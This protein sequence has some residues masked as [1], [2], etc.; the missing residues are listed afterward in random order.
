VIDPTILAFDPLGSS[1]GTEDLWRAPVQNTRWGWNPA[2]AAQVQAPT[3]VIRG[4]LDTQAPE[5]GVRDL[6][7]DLGTN[8]KVFVHVACAAHQ[9]VWETQHMILLRASREWLRH[10]TFAG[11]DNGSFAVDVNGV[12]HEE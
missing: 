3:L 9:L 12:V 6:Y 2:S 7:A 11:H 4:D 5:P 10:G 8:Q 1:W